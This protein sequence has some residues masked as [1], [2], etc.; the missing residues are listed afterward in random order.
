MHTHFKFSRSG[1]ENL[2]TNYFDAWFRFSAR[3]VGQAS[4]QRCILNGRPLFGGHS[5]LNPPFK[6]W[7]NIKRAFDT[8]LFR[9][10]RELLLRVFLTFHGSALNISCFCGPVPKIAIIPRRLR[11]RIDHALRGL[12]VAALDRRHVFGILGGS[13]A[14]GDPFVCRVEPLAERDHVAGFVARYRV[15]GK[16]DNL[17]RRN[18]PIKSQRFN[19]IGR[20]RE[21][22][23]EFSLIPKFC[24]SGDV[25]IQ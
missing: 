25:K 9:H 13:D 1:L 11:C 24:V 2:E 20:I 10:R 8:K 15:G 22:F 5:H 18:H 21:C 23:V 3:P 16:P 6:N 4:C 7:S 19:P 14:E 17:V 12:Q